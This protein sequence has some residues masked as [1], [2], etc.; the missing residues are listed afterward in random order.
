MKDNETGFCQSLWG[1]SEV[2]WGYKK[3]NGNY[4]GLL[5]VWNTNIFV[6]QECEGNGFYVLKGCG[7]VTNLL[8]L[9]STFIL[10]A[11]WLE[12]GCCGRN[13]GC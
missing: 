8:V 11:A 2:N 7:A 10:H 4:G 3:S 1:S 12:R 5:C 9:C 6:L 13:C